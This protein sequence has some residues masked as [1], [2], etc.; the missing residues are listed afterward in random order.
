MDDVSL[1]LV[2]VSG[3]IL[4]GAAGEIIFA[5]T[6][7]PD[8]IWLVGAGILLG[9]VFEVVPAQLL[10]P[11]IPYFGAI[12]LTVILAG[13]AYRLQLTEV[14]SAAPRGLLL[15]TVGFAFSLAGVCVFLWAGIQTGWI[16][17]ATVLHW[18]LVGGIVGGTSALVIMPTVAGGQVESRVARTLEV[19]SSAT[20]ALCVVVT[21]ALLD[22]LVHGSTGV[23]DPV[24]TLIRRSASAWSPGVTW[25]ILMI[26]F[27]AA[28]RERFQSYTL[29]IA[30][31]FLLYALT[32]WWQG[33]GAMAVLI[34]AL[35]LGNAST[36]V[37]R[38]IP[39]A[40]PH[41]FIPSA[42]GVTMQQQLTFL[43]KAFFFV[44]IG[45]MF[46][47]DTRSIVIGVLAGATLLVFRIPAV[48]LSVGG[49]GFSFKQKALLMVAAPRGL[50][51][52]VLATLPFQH[53]IPGMES[54]AGIV[55][56]TIVTTIVLF[57]VGFALVARLPE[58]PPSDAAG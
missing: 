7:I 58:P 41:A 26:P 35:L 22:L 54:L 13:G 16:R 51:A 5:K 14:A 46:P 49:L 18:L 57:A 43:V 33:N 50:A 55:F 27:Y 21:M 39:G 47:D 28:M 4:L 17:D 29:L 10:Q 42:S 34:S 38:L 15:G 30:S 44:I 12:A 52:G 40:H 25:S 3:L 45:L 9:P 1:M 23:A 56:S 36:I 32:T 24:L 31:M 37:P 8:P 53:N 48:A 11:A 2:V 20:D 19:E 6:R